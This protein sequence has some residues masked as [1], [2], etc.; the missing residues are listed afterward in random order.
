MEVRIITKAA[1]ETPQSA[2][3][4]DLLPGA[5]LRSSKQARRLYSRVDVC[6]CLRL[7]IQHQK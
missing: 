3:Q 2:A 5:E 4:S 6:T 7:N 1:P